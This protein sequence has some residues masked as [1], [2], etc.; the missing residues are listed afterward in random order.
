MQYMLVNAGNQKKRVKT[1]SHAQSMH[2]NETIY[3]WIECGMWVKT[4]ENVILSENVVTW[5]NIEKQHV[6]LSWRAAL[7][8]FSVLFLLHT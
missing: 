4:D 6:R 1:L 3:G 8:N 5:K 7:L 2:K